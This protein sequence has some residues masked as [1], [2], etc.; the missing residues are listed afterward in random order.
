MDTGGAGVLGCSQEAS[1]G[2]EEEV[3][4]GW[5]RRGWDRGGQGLPGR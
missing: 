2:Q 1:G 5:V 4:W 3:W